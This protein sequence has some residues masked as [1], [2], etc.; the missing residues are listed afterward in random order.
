MNKPI[1]R[2]D[3]IRGSALA[4]AAAGLPFSASAT[5]AVDGS[6]SQVKPLSGVP[7]QKKGGIISISIFSKHLQWLNYQDMAKL[8]ADI[9][10]DGIDLTVRPGGH[11][12]PENVSMDLPKAV[13]VIQKAGLKVHTITTDIKTADQPHIEAILKAASRAGITNY[14]MGWYKYNSEIGVMENIALFNKDFVRMAALNEKYNIQGNYQNHVDRFGNSIWDLWLAMKD[15][16]PA[17][18]SS[19]FD[20][21]HAV[22]D[23]A[24]AWPIHMDLIKTH[25]GSLAIKDFNW[26]NVNNKWLKENVPLGQGMV[27]FKKYFALIKKYDLKVPI[28]LHYEFPLGGADKGAKSLSIP[29]DEFVKAIKGDLETLK[30]WLKTE[31]L[32]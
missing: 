3:F 26:K 22:I 19:Q 24:D 28:S 20:I 13:E 18:L 12:T 16:N 14:R 2:K 10:F 4:V 32:I 30:G 23:G 31:Q 27:D 6:G 21:R 1:S 7:S 17:Y 9:G 25:I 29:R 15:I 11:I 5:T 8:T